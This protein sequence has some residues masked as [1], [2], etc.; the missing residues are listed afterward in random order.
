M[1]IISIKKWNTIQESNSKFQ[2]SKVPKF[3]SFR[4]SKESKFRSFKVPQIPSFKIPKL[5]R[6]NFS[7]FQVTKVIQFPKWKSWIKFHSF[8]L[9]KCEIAQIPEFQDRWG[10]FYFASCESL[11]FP[12]LILL[13]MSWDCSWI[14]LD[15]SVSWKSGISV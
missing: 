4:V 6:F 3:Q 9:S 13:K 10:L 15:N 2:D 1:Y 5:Q 14:N 8:H 7:K 11:I 12:K